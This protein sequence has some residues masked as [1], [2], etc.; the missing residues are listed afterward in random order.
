[1]FPS[2]EH[3][4]AG[5][6]PVTGVPVQMSGTPGCVRGGAPALGEHTRA[7]L[8]SLLHIGEEEL[9]RLLAAGVI[10]AGE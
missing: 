8:A 9:N 6:F 2:V 4:R 7:V 5:M 10:Y 1:M 3:G